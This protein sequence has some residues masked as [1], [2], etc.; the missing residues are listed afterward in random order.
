MRT[1]NT[2]TG[3]WPDLLFCLFVQNV[4]STTVAELLE[5]ESFF[6]CFL[7]LVATITDGFA[8][9]TLEL[10]HVVLGHIGLI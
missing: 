9:C 8:L 7:V 4:L 5:F 3:A 2:K 1:A 6:D 10:D